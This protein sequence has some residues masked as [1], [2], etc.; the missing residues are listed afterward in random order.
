MSKRP[1]FFIVGAPKCGTT[2]MSEYLK[3]H[4]DIFISN[5]KEPHYFAEDIKP[6]SCCNTLEDYLQLFD[7]QKKIIGEASVLYLYSDYAIKNIYSFNP[8]AKIVVMIRNYID[9]IYSYHSQLL[10]NADEEIKNFEIAW[11]L[12]NNR[13]SGLNIPKSCRVEKLLYYREVGKL[14]KQVERLL[15]IFPQEQ[16]HFILFD[17]FKN[18][19]LTVY[20]ELLDF[21]EVPYDGRV[22]FP[23]INENKQNKFQ[24]LAKLRNNP[25][26]FLMNGVKN[27]KKILGIENIHFMK[28]LHDLNK[29]KVKRESLSIKMKKEILDT[30]LED[31]ELLESLINKDLNKWKSL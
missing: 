20:K 25:P 10:L 2:A 28:K 8:E 1:N 27:V 6:Y 3:T 24:T 15:N 22:E 16:V 4:P 14:G 13:K 29:K 12:E 7:T 19:T 9:Y 5:P 23:V 18:N 21:L 26:A 31:I 11:K 30:F 17:D